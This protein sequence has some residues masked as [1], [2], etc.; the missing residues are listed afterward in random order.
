MNSV[1]VLPMIQKKYGS[2]DWNNWEIQRWQ[3]FDTVSY[4]HAG[5]N[6]LNFF[7][8]SQGGVDPIS[9]RQKTL[10]QTNMPKSRSFGQVYFIIQEIRTYV[11]FLAKPRQPA[12]INDDAKTIT[13]KMSAAMDKY[14][15]LMRRGV[16]N[17]KIGQKDYFDIRAPFTACPPGFGIEITQPGALLEAAGNTAASA[18]AYQNTS[19]ANV[20]A[21]TPPQMIEPEQS[22][23]VTI[24][25]ATTSPVFTTLVNSTSPSIDIMVCF[26]GYIARPAQ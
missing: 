24:D 14:L 21:V 2:A 4:P 18:W 25:F 5:T 9:S 8:I 15:E 1:D 26:D 12:G 6:Q 13:G 23:D 19:R 10:E 7:A 3:F 20:Y 16:L 17:I 22:I 11:N